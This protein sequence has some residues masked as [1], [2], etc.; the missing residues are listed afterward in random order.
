MID[1]SEEMA[2]NEL[3]VLVSAFPLDADVNDPLEPVG[4]VDDAP[5]DAIEVSAALSTCVSFACV[6]EAMFWVS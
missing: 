5:P 2:S 4:S 3:D 6:G 1:E